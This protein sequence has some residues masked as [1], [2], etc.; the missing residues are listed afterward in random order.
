MGKIG[1]EI[2]SS[3]CRYSYFEYSVDVFSPCAYEMECFDKKNWSNDTVNGN[4]RFTFF[5]FYINIVNGEEK[6]RTT[7]NETSTLVIDHD[8]L[9]ASVWR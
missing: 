9:I 1:N 6:R 8:L 7:I 3:P 4:F 5:R 2:L